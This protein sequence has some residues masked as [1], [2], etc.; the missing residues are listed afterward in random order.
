MIWLTWRQFRTQALAAVAILAAATIYMLVTGFQI[1]DAYNADE[2]TCSRPQSQC[3]LLLNN[4][5]GAYT[6]PQQLFQ[7]LLIA[8]PALIGIFWGAP[9]IAGELE[10][11][12]HRMTWNQSVTPARWL[13]VKL[14]GVGLAAVATT[15][16]LSLLLTWWA[17][18]LDQ[19]A[20][21]RFSSL[22]F[23]TRNVVPLGYAAFA[24]SL[25]VAL[26]LVTRRVLT[27]MALVLAVFIA[28]QILFATQIRTNLLP[29]TTVAPAVNSALLS[30]AHGIDSPA[31][32]DGSVYVFQP[33]PAGDWIQSESAI[34]DSSGRVISDDQVGSCLNNG[35]T[36]LAAIGTCL[37]P[38][39]LH[40][41]LKYQPA[42]NYW[43][44]QWAETGIYL[45]LAV[46]LTGSAF[47]RLRHHHD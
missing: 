38:Y 30:R 6:G 11:G 25:G 43:P 17:S 7:L 36:S 2:A 4:L 22:V 40:I 45:A 33:L 8:A 14:A 28:L 13:A 19:I 46:L 44:L 24:F 10:R 35:P 1:R 5:Q 15:G 9:L 16:L 34:E 3:V 32:G 37:A 20:E 47:W 21:N 18:P 27:A 42:D 39:D 29:S 26:G 31:G 12:T 41:E 23:S